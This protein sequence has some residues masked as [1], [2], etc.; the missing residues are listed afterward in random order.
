LRAHS[1]HGDEACNEV[2]RA[3]I[4]TWYR[5]RHCGRDHRADCRNPEKN[6]PHNAT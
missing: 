3:C 5:R 4:P 6:V 2:C 1:Q